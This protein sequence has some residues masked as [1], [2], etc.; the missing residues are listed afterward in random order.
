M[1]ILSKINWSGTKHASGST[2]RL[3]SSRNSGT[4]TCHYDDNSARYI[5]GKIKLCTGCYR[6]YGRP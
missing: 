1:G 2:Q 4:G 6:R 5:V 3:G